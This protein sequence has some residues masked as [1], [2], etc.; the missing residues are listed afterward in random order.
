V[1]ALKPQVVIVNNG[2]TKGWQNSAFETVSKIQGLEDVWQIHSA[3]GPNHDH[4]VSAERIANLEP[5]DR[6]KGMS[7]RASVSK[8]GQFTVTNSR[9]QFSKTYTAR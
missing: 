7:I 6:C 1:L 8:D 9:N 4:N 3:M 2:P 5:T